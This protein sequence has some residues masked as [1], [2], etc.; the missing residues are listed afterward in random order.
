MDATAEFGPMAS[1]L[2]E[3]SKTCK[4][5]SSGGEMIKQSASLKLVDLFRMSLEIEKANFS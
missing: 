1:S 5:T 3:V 4:T 2:V